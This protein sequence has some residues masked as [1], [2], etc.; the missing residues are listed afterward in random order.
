MIF[1]D[2]EEDDILPEEQLERLQHSPDV[3][4][5]L[6]NPHLC[7]FLRKVDATHNP[8]GFLRVAM[9]EPLFV[10]FADACLAAIHPEIEKEK[11][12]VRDQKVREMI[13]VAVEDD[14]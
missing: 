10:E 3:L 5:C 13:G 4:A 6:A 2:E 8:K 11:K 14:A 9:Q 12:E 1:L 7:D